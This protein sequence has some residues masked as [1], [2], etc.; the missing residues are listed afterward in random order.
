M[1]ALVALNLAHPV[2]GRRDGEKRE[3]RRADEFKYMIAIM[4]DLLAERRRPRIASRSLN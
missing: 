4:A 3:E 1:H 2:A